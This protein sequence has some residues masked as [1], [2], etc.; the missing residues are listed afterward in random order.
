MLSPASRRWR[1]HLASLPLDV[2][3]LPDPLP[4]PGPDDFII[5]GCPRTGTTLL[6]AA[7][8][9]PPGVVTVME[10]WDGMRM[11]PQELFASLRDEVESTGRLTRGRMAIRDGAVRW[12]T[13]GSAPVDVAV[14]P[15]WKLGV[16]WPGY[17]RYL[18]RLPSTKFLVC[19]R[20][21]AEVIASLAALRGPGARGLQFETVFNRRLN[22]DLRAA[23]DDPVV[24]RSLLYEYV[25][26]RILPHVGRPEVM[27]VHY[28]RWFTDAAGLLAEIGRFLGTDV[29]HPPVRVRPR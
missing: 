10:P 8:F 1:R 14:E 22:D 6:C 7:L 21:P 16:K 24:R 17:W 9:Q 19:V 4:A 26:E 27:V 18:D 29:S 20:D 5:C 25:N 15:G 2:D 3:A 28:E 11:P 23:T 12:V 13:E